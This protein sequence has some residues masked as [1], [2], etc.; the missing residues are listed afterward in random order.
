MSKKERT[1]VE[2]FEQDGLGIFSRI[3][4]LLPKHVVN[5]IFDPLGAKDLEEPEKG[6]RFAFEMD[7]PM[8]LAFLI[9]HNATEKFS[10]T[11]KLIKNLECCAECAKREGK[12]TKKDEADIEHLQCYLELSRFLMKLFDH[13]VKAKF[14]K[15]DWYK[16]SEHGLI[17]LAFRAGF[18][19]YYKIIPIEEIQ[20]P[21]FLVATPD[22][23]SF[24]SLADLFE[25]ADFHT[26]DDSF[27]ELAKKAGVEIDPGTTPGKA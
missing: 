14:K 18:K 8:K 6:E 19:V 11:F 25:Q 26:L 15:L 20:Q 27:E 22:A 7:L 5:E 24:S 21:N 12:L 17:E 16:K 3:M 1:L 4:E 13:H 2:I 9:M 10:S 23:G